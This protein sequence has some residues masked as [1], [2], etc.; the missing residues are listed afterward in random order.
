MGETPDELKTKIEQT[1]QEL[2]SDVD[3]IADRVSPSRI[4]RRRTEAVRGAAVSARTRVMGGMSSAGDT[5]SGAPSAV[6]DRA[7]GNPLAAGLV[8]FGAGLLLASLM[9]STAAEEHAA[10]GLQDVSGGLVDSA[11]QLAQGQAQQAKETLLP[12]A[13]EAAADLKETATDAAQATADH[14]KSASSDMAADAQ[15]T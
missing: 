13:K 15:R 2:T 12:A 7:Q 9:P 14:A 4:A 5:A 3:S 1:R 6:V 8:A 11:K 10:A